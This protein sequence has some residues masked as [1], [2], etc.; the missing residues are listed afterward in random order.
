VC[1]TLSGVR[2]F[3][4]A[5]DEGLVT[6]WQRFCGDLDLVSVHY[7]SILDLSC[8][9]IVSPANSFGFMDGGIDVLYMNFLWTGDSGQGAGVDRDSTPW[10]TTCRNG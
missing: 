9:A 7:G 2:V 1:A 8:D 6:A 5:I 10:R 4:T 3:L